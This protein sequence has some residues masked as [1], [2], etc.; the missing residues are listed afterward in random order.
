MDIKITALCLTHCLGI[1]TRKLVQAINKKYN[2]PKLLSENTKNVSTSLMTFNQN[3]EQET[4]FFTI[5]MAVV[6]KKLLK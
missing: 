3:F 4:D 5:F 1:P 6:S 2:A